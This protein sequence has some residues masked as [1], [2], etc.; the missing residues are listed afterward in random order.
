MGNLEI[1]ITVYLCFSIL[2][3]SF[4]PSFWD[5]DRFIR[6]I[7]SQYHILWVAIGYPACTRDTCSGMKVNY[8]I[9]D[10]HFLS[11]CIQWLYYKY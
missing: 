10:G 11:V 8:E 9:V 3:S 5:S 6:T 4:L 2:S 7:I 1:I